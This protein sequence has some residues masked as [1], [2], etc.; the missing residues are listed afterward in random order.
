MAEYI[1]FQLA[2]VLGEFVNRSSYTPGQLAKLSGIPKPTIV[3]W[4]VGRVRRPRIPHD[5]L[6]LAV[7]LHLNQAEVE[8]LLAAAEHPGLADLTTNAS[9]T[10]DAEMLALAANWLG[11][12]RKIAGRETVGHVPFQATAD[13]STFVGREEEIRALRQALVVDEHKTVYSVQGMAGVGKTALVA[14]LAYQLRPFFPDGVLWAQADTSDVMSILDTF[15][16]AYAV[17]V[18]HYADIHSRSQVVRELLADKR[19]LVVLDNVRE[20]EPVKLLLPPTG[21]CA[22]VITTRRHDL[23]L[24]RGAYRLALGPFD[25]QREESLA[26]F[27]RTMDAGR[28]ERERE[29]LATLADVLGHL[30]LAIDIAASRIAYEPGWSAA[31]FLRRVHQQQRRLAELAYEDQSVRVS[32]AASYDSL[33]PE[34]QR[35][36]VAMSVFPGVDFDEQAA[37]QVATLPIEQAQD[38]LRRLYGLSLVQPGRAM[39][40]HVAQQPAR[41]RLHPLLR[42]YAQAQQEDPTVKQRFVEHYVAFVTTHQRHYQM[43]WLEMS[44]ILTALYW[45][46][47]SAGAEQSADESAMNTALVSGA[48]AFYYFLEARG[49][50]TLAAELLAKARQAASRLNDRVLMLPVYRCLGRLAQRQGE[51]VTAEAHYETALKLAQQTGD[52]ASRSDVLRALGVLAARRGDY[53]LAD[54]Y[55]KEGLALARQLGH[56]S[57]ASDFLRGLGVQAYMRG[58]PITAEAFYEEGLALLDTAADEH[59]STLWGLGVLAEEQ[60]DQN[61][62]EAYYQEALAQ[63]RAADHQERIIILLRSLGGLKVDQG[64]YDEATTYLA[65]ALQLAR[66]IGHRWLTGRLLDHWGELHLLTQRFDPA[67]VAFQELYELARIIQSQDMVGGALY[68]LAR[69]AAAQGN[70]DRARQLGEESQDNYTAIGHFKVNEVQEW[71]ATF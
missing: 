36:F 71:L 66:K 18:R 31:E 15:A 52:A 41:Y 26:L 24:T 20:S 7:V 9:Q 49:Q 30:P 57:A 59:P 27:A 32:F 35:F 42:D 25:P 51:Y 60:G 69:V 55:Y 23:S 39:A 3:N 56:G 58:D 45:A 50:Y 64:R 8:S 38:H 6:R 43:L 47:E 1:P 16:S 12:R 37:A 10:A 29:A 67:Q 40:Q 14:H 4:L 44:N 68:G 65:E 19:A 2:D 13:L 70:E 63:V 22:V 17:D 11:D 33:T 46:E 54:A 53:G 34:L 5:L 21:P 48:T 62:A 61:Q 28:V